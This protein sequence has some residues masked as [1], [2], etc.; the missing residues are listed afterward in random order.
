M[1]AYPRWLRWYQR[2]IEALAG[3]SLFVIVCVMIAQV[4]AR[5]VFG[6][7]LIWAEE[8]CRYLLIW[9]TFLLLGLAYQRGDFVMLDILPYMLSARA[10]L[11]LKLVVAIP[12]LVFL[13]VIVATGWTYAS[14]FQRQTIPAVDFIWTNLFGHNL[15]LTVRWIY[16]SVPVGA[17]LLAAHVIADAVAS[18][19]AFRTGNRD[20]PTNPEP[21]EAV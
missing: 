20:I 8:I 15:G 14:L 11:M 16:L 10:R 6:G 17:L 21:D 12:I 1:Q 19:V 7:S 13:A 2:A 9:Q 18:V 5:Y 3:A 4:L